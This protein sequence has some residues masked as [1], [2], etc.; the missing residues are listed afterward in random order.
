MVLIV[1]ETQ[2]VSGGVLGIGAVIALILGGLLL[3]QPIGDAAPDA[4]QRLLHL[5]PQRGD[6][7]VS[8]AL[9]QEITGQ[10]A[11]LVQGLSQHTTPPETR[12]WARSA[13]PTGRVEK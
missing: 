11:F 1:L 6:S 12:R 3:F 9:F 7:F 13:S 4:F 8:V 5:G 2:V 10:A